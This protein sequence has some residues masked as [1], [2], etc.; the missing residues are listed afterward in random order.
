MEDEAVTD[1]ADDRANKNSGALPDDEAADLRRQIRHRLES[2]YSRTRSTSPDAIDEGGSE[3]ART[4]R[5]R[6]L[7]EEEDAFY[8]ERGLYRCRNHRG[9]YE[10]LTK[11]DI[12]RRRS[13]RHR[14]ESGFLKS[15]LSGSIVRDIANGALVVLVVIALVILFRHRRVEEEVAGQNAEYKIEIQS[16]PP[17]AAI[18]VDGVSTG[19]STNATVSI[20]K[21]GYHDVSVYR[22]GYRTMPE[23]QR[24][25]VTGEG[26]AHALTFTLYELAGQR[27]ADSTSAGDTT[28]GMN[29]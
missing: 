16:E 26:A 18:F 27:P 11:E 17:G 21:P 5:R 3:S 19:R 12:E 29:R 15:L 1:Q 9:E 4:E 24:I 20:R 13:R 22:P 14:K 7:R 6:I 25:T 8:A 2:E 23:S 28:L 10:W